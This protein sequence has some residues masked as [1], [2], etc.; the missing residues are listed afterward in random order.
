MINFQGWRDQAEYSCPKNTKN[1]CTADEK[2]GFDWSDLAEGT[3][4]KYKGY[5]FSG[6]D[7]ASKLG[8]RNLEGRTFSVG[9][10]DHN[11][12]LARSI[13]TYYRANALKQI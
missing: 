2:N 6:W 3:F 11:L 7:C 1:D 4:D 5:S 12:V 9:F 10:S 13:L 8:K